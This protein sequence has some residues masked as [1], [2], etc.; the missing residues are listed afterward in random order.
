MFSKV[1][2]E[3]LYLA[4]MFIFGL[5]LVFLIP[6]FNSPDE[7]SHFKKAYLVSNGIFYPEV[8]DGVV[9]N[10]IPSNMLQLIEI[11]KGYGANYQEKY[12]YQK[13]LMDLQTLGI[14]SDTTF[15]EY[16]TATINPIIYIIPAS[17]IWLANLFSNIIGIKP[18]I[19]NMLYGARIMSLIVYSLLIYFAIKISPRFKK[20]LLLFALLPMSVAL[21]SCVSYDSLLIVATFL[22]FG[23]VMNLRYSSDKVKKWHFI[24]LGI[25]IFIYFNLKYIYILNLFMLLLIPA[26]K[27]LKDKKNIIK[28]CFFMLIAV[29]MLTVITKYKLITLSGIEGSN[30]PSEQVHFILNNPFS[31][32]K[33]YFSTLLNNRFFY[34]ST[35]IGVF[36]L[37]DTY[38]PTAF[39]IIYFIMSIIILLSDCN[40]KARE[41]LAIP[42]YFKI[43]ALFVC[44]GII[45]LSF[46]AMYVNWTSILD[47]YGVGASSISGVQGRYF[48]PALIPIIIIFINKFNSKRFVKLREFVNNNYGYGFICC[49]LIMV[50]TILIRFWM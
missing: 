15:Q 3:N 33:I 26:N 40:V 39:Y 35:F 38:L 46:L 28:K 22:L 47:G 48:I 43:I 6:P 49:F 5:L 30:L 4:I 45:S 17:G 2:E 13:F 10:E 44:F 23:I 34:L 12:D 7:D 8:R 14:S 11:Y 32:I 41:Q 21:I 36:G 25:I 20:S 1:R 18:T 9:G 27:L 37:L 19:T 29:I 16:T 50:V 42:I 24:F 31:Y